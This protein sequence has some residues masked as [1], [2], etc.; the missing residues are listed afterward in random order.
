MTESVSL[1]ELVLG[2]CQELDGLV[3]PPAYGTYEVLLPDEAATRWG[4][5]PHLRLAFTPGSEKALHIHFGHTLVDSIVEELRQKTANARFFINNVRLEKPRLYEVIEK[6]FS[7]PNAKMFPVPGSAQKIQTHHCVQLNFKV[8]LIADE[9]RELILPMWMDLQGGYA[10]KSAEIERLA[11][12]EPDNDFQNIPSASLLWSG[13][14]LFSPNAMTALLERARRSAA[15]ELGDTLTSLQKRLKRF[16]ELDRARLNDYYDHLQKDAERR[17]QK[18]EQDRRPALEDKL[19]AIAAERL[20]KL[21]DVEQKYHLHTQLELINLAVISQP[22]L[23][24]MVEISKRGVAVKRRAT[25]DPLLHVVEG[26]VCDVCGQPGYTLFLCENGHLAH[27]DCLAPQCVECKRTFCQ[28]CA[29]EVL[30]CVVCERPVCIHSM[31]RCSECGR[32]ICHEH[33]GECHADAG[34]PRRVLVEQPVSQDPAPAPQAAG[35]AKSDTGGTGKAPRQKPPAKKQVSKARL[36]ASF[37]SLTKTRPEVTGEYMEVQAIPA[38][39]LIVAWVLV[40]KREIATRQ[41]TMTDRGIGV[42]CWCEKTNCPEQGIVYRPAPAEQI[43]EQMMSFIEDFALEYGVP[44]KKIRYFH[45]RLGKQF[46]ESSLKVPASWKEP[47]T[48]ERAWEGFDTLRTK[49]RK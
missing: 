18:A 41:W 14:S 29:D 47:A 5:K 8:S 16:L 36:S 3:E 9:K 11:I 12:L 31:H 25:L 38:E 46:P 42:D 2:Y 4:M 26:L 30:S 45:F 21:A 33:A 48:L 39:N 35:G 37:E 20:A 13:E 44:L 23:D 24:L 49:N 27:G 32:S 28:K 40:K 1:E 22:K 17:L 15:L 6:A 34:Q 19:S 10:V 7:L 43:K